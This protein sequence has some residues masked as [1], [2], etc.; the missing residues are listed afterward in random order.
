MSLTRKLPIHYGWLIVFSGTLTLFACL[1]M[2]RFAFGLLLPAMQQSLALGYDQM[3]LISTGNFIGYLISVALS[4]WLIKRYRPRAVI[5]S[6]LLLICLCM[7]VIS[8]AD[9]LISLV[10]FYGLTGVGSGF[11]NIPTMVLVAHWFR[12]NKRGQA[13]GII[14]SGSAFAIILAGVVVPI[15]NADYGW[16]SSWV[17]LALVSLLAAFVALLVVRNDPSDLGLKP[18]GRFE[19]IESAEMKG[20]SCGGRILLQLGVI[21]M[22]FGLTY[23]VYGTYIVISMVDDFG[24][25]EVRAGQLWSWVGFFAIFSGALLGSISDRIGRRN[26]MILVYSLFT[27][28]YLLAGLGGLLGSWAIWLSILFYGSV[29][30][31]MPAIIAAAVV[32]YLGIEQAASGFSTLTLFFAAGQ[33]IG[34]GSAGLLAEI[35]KTFVPSY[36]VSAALTAVAIILSLKLKTPQAQNT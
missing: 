27:C 23:M 36:L 1:G 20:K 33:I 14:V 18:C 35:S 10:F 12:R 22:I 2:A 28:A 24:F 17:M 29:L 9:S 11:A 26:T 5:C 25:S 31:A 30:F 15:I 8:R 7:L 19:A 6:G 16:R 4:P 21:Y 3:G 34:P 13:A 32:D